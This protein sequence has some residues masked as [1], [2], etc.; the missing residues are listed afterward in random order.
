VLVVE[1]EAD[2]RSMI[3]D[4][5]RE[6]GC[7]VIEAADGSAGLREIQSGTH[8]DLLVTDVGLPGMNGRQLADAARED[9]SGLPVLLITGYAG[10]ALEDTGLPPGM[11]VM[12]KPFALET[13]AAR[14]GTLLK[15]PALSLA[16]RPPA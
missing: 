13:L 9:R 1:D 11:D 3:A 6:L 8:F 14:V 16:E 2:V 5:L 12:R 7:R 10:T 4:V 15:L